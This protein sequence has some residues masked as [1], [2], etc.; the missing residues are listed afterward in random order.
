MRKTMTTARNFLVA[1]VGLMHPKRSIKRSMKAAKHVV[2][3]ISETNYNLPIRLPKE[4][5]E[6]L[7]RLLLPASTFY[8]CAFQN[9]QQTCAIDFGE[10]R[11]INPSCHISDLQLTELALPFPVDW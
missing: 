6:R 11:P 7:E 1:S 9:L 3:V 4:V 5:Q 2:R 10:A 8:T